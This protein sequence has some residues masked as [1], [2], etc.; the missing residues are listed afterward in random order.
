M[1]HTVKHN[2][3]AE[4]LRQETRLQ[5][6]VSHDLLFFELKPALDKKK[7]IRKKPNEEKEGRGFKSSFHISFLLA[8]RGIM[9]FSGSRK[10]S[11]VWFWPIPAAEEGGT[12][13]LLREDY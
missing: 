9:S 7:S 5:V 3:G 6:V 2:S 1:S 12:D 10:T 4:T 8:E 11:W 13:E